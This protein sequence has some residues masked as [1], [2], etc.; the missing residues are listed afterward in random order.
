M[1]MRVHRCKSGC[2]CDEEIVD[3]EERWVQLVGVDE[4]AKKMNL[5]FQ[6]AAMFKPLLI[7]K[8]IVEKWPRR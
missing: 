8:R 7:V 4:E 2:E 3:N 6:V 1:S 5:S